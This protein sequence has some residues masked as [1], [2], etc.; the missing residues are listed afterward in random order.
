MYSCSP[1][2]D[3]GIN[4]IQV[5]MAC[6]IHSNVSFWQS[7]NRL[8]A[9][10]NIFSNALFKYAVN[11]FRSFT[12]CNSLSRVHHINIFI[13][14][15]SNCRVQSES[16]LQKLQV[17]KFLVHFTYFNVQTGSIA[18]QGFSFSIAW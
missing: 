18:V 9:F 3:S 4:A 14:F 2:C 17:F 5:A 13:S 11:K 8:R 10:K 16:V 15:Y 6:D 1:Y 7:N 12:T